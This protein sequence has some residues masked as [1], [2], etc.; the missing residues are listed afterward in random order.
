MNFTQELDYEFDRI[1]PQIETLQSKLQHPKR[2]R[3]LFS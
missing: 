2:I 3:K 1:Q